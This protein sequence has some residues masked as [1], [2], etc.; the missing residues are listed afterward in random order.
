MERQKDQIDPWFLSGESW[1]P[2]THEQRAAEA[3]D[4]IINAADRGI[5]VKRV[6]RRMAASAPQYFG[7]TIIL[8]WRSS[9]AGPIGQEATGFYPPLARHDLRYEIWAKAVEPLT[10]TCSQMMRHTIAFYESSSDPRV[11][12]VRLLNLQRAVGVALEHLSSAL[13]R[14]VCDQVFQ[15]F[16]SLDF[17]ALGWIQ[18]SVELYKTG[19]KEESLDV[20]FDTIDEMLLASKFDECDLALSKIPVNNLSNAQ[21]LT[22]LTATLAAKE[23]LSNRRSLVDRVKKQLARRGAD[24]TGLMMGLD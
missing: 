20:I 4:L 19:R 8:S 15:D 3:A 13:N 21:L 5:S 1:H 10:D 17:P 23:H 16:P 11:G 14:L 6:L 7:M 22:I 9:E 12:V 18:Q 24:V 2:L